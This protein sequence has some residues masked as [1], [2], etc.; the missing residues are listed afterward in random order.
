MDGR[1]LETSL[2]LLGV[3]VL[4]G[5]LSWGMS[6]F[7]VGKMTPEEIARLSA[8]P[9]PTPS[10]TPTVSI[11]TSGADIESV[12]LEFDRI[13]TP[14]SNF[15]KKYTEVSTKMG[16]TEIATL[17]TQLVTA[18]GIKSATPAVIRELAQKLVKKNIVPNLDAIRALVSSESIL[19]TKSKSQVLAAI[20]SEIGWQNLQSEKIDAE[21]LTIDQ[22][23]VLTLESQTHYDKTNLEILRLMIILDAS[24]LSATVVQ[25]INGSIVTKTEARINAILLEGK[26]ISLAQ[27]N[28]NKAKKRAE[29]MAT[30]RL[31]LVTTAT[32]EV[33]KKQYDELGLG[34]NNYAIDIK[35][36]LT[37]L[38]VF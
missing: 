30:T 10:V 34:M 8:T 11:I 32:Y 33:A 28:L 5:L 20:D 13:Y 6:A 17:S 26:E 31:L 7:G 18:S 35:N 14:W 37:I 21:T 22:I 24:D 19:F 16:T 38:K 3:I 12:S 9:T 23:K 4:L 25:N 1:G 27:E 29:G 36:T 2:K 15:E